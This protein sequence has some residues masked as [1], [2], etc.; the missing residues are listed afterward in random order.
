MRSLTLLAAFIALTSASPTR[1]R[2]PASSKLLTDI[3]EIQKYW[4]QLTPYSNNAEDL[5]GVEDVGLQM[6]ARSNRST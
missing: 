3:D 4:G 1:R 2:A 6:A 5:F